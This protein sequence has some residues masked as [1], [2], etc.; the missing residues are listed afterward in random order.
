MMGSGVPY[1]YNNGGGSSFSS[2]NLSPLAPPFTVDRSVAIPLLDL[3]EPTYPVSLNPSLHNWATS[4][5]HI[6]NSRPDLF[7]LPNLEFDSIPS[8]NVFGY[9]SA[10]PQVTSKNHPLVLASTDAVLYGQSNPSLVEAV[11][12]YPSSYVSPAIGSDGHLKIPHQS[13]YE[14]LSNSYVGTS[15][16]S[17][18]DDYTQSSLGLEHATQWSGLWEGVTDWNQSKKLQLD[19]GFCEKENFI[20]QG[21]LVS[22]FCFVITENQFIVSVSIKLSKITFYATLSLAFC[23]CRFI[24]H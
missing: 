14:L 1:G 9:S 15:N 20:N 18:H 10:T 23:S 13:G 8:P 4:N 6:P 22:L 11:P 12:Y 5:S 7:P 3:T 17:S 24:P 2:S 19:G 21:I 16:G